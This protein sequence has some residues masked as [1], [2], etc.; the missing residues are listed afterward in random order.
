VPIPQTPTKVRK[1]TVGSCGI[2]PFEHYS[3]KLQL[4][5]CQIFEGIETNDAIDIEPCV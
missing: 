1:I 4:I 2:N 5:V 3:H